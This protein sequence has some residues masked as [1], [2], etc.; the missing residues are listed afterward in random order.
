MLATYM[1][2]MRNN[3]LEITIAGSSFRPQSCMYAFCLSCPSATF[4]LQQAGFVSRE[5]LVAKGL[6]LVH[7][8]RLP[9]SWVQ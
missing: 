1:R 7:S 4:A 2:R 5:W 8:I 3:N 9:I 6:I